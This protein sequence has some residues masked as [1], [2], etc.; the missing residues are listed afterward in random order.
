[1]W[2]RGISRGSVI[3]AWRGVFIY[4]AIIFLMI[5][6]IAGL[7]GL[8]GVIAPEVAELVVALFTVLFLIPFLPAWPRRHQESNQTSGLN[9]ASLA[10]MEMSRSIRRDSC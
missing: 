8:S 10:S 4:W 6:V 7:V 9:L 1:M 2:F 5:A 3:V